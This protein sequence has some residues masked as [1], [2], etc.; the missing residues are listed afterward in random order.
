[1]VGARCQLKELRHRSRALIG[2][3]ATAVITDQQRRTFTI[4]NK[5]N[6]FVPFKQA[7]KNILKKNSCS[8]MPLW[9]RA[10]QVGW[11][12]KNS[13][14]FVSF[15]LIQFCHIS[16]LTLLTPSLPNSGLLIPGLYVYLLAAP[17]MCHA[18]SPARSVVRRASCLSSSVILLIFAAH[19]KQLRV[20]PRCGPTPV[21]KHICQLTVHHL[22]ILL[23]RS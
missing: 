1:M 5:F 20:D 6:D 7:L 10:P 12:Q 11:K 22:H 21:P 8:S 13:C 18:T 15:V 19:K 17:P 23:C 16:G 2:Y 4:K 9:G 14:S 3:D